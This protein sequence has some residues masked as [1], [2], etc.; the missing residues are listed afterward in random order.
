[1]KK[2][3]IIL[4]FDINTKKVGYCYTL[5][6]KPFLNHQDHLS[7]GT[8][9]MIANE[10]KTFKTYGNRMLESNKYINSLMREAY[11]LLESLRTKTMLKKW[12]LKKIYVI[13]EKSD[14]ATKFGSVGTT[15]KLA[16]YTG[17]IYFAITDLIISVVPQ[18]KDK[19]VVKFVSPK[20]W[21]KK[22]N[23]SIGNPKKQSIQNANKK[24][25]EWGIEKTKDDDLADAINM[26]ILAKKLRDGL[27]IQMQNKHKKKSN[28]SKKS[29]ILKSEQIILS[30][31][32]RQ[33]ERNKQGKTKW[34]KRDKVLF[35][36]HKDIILKL[37]GEK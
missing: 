2:I 29:K 35:E 27:T 33:M 30:I 18:F 15:T 10:K 25:I 23:F 28:Q 6:G 36:K 19:I 16:L 14:I 12:E 20:E 17:A 21:Q 4:S 5:N 31:E 1:M 9:K 7:L 13:I 11:F 26:N 34:L 37:K 3:D 32:K 22:L 24:L 8:M